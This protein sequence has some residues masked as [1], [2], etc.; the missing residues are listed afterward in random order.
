LQTGT[1]ITVALF[2][3]RLG[4]MHSWTARFDSLPDG[5]SASLVNG[6]GSG[7][8]SPSNPQVANCLRSEDGVCT[9]MNNIRFSPDVAGQYVIK[10]TASLPQTDDLGP[11]TATYTIVAEVEGE[12]AS[13][14]C[15]AASG[16]L[17]ALALG[18]FALIR[19]R[20]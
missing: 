12:S 7:A 17:A 8:T 1:D 9:E 19:R 4:Q 6:K 13:G 14:G 10:V 20:R 5:S 3:N 2:S 11:S 16:S 15:A 18:L